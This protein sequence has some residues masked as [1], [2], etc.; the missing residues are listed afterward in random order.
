M[1]REAIVNAAK[2]SIDEHGIFCVESPEFERLLG[3]AETEGRAW[4]IFFELLNEYVEAERDGS[5][6][7]TAVAKELGRKGGSVTSSAKRAAARDNG[8]KGGRPRNKV[9]VT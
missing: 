1:N 6:V 9:R 2:C 3:S 4:E 5:L 8:A 7:H